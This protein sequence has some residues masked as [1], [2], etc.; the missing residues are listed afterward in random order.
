MHSKGVSKEICEMKEMIWPKINDKHSSRNNYILTFFTLNYASTF[1]IWERIRWPHIITFTSFSPSFRFLPLCTLN[2]FNFAYS[3]SLLWRAGKSLD[4]V[5]VVA[6]NATSI[7]VRFTLPQI[8]VGL[9]GHAELVFTSQP[10]LP[11]HEWNI[12]KFARPKRLFDTPNIEYHLSN[13]KP[14]TTYYFQ[15]RIVVEA[16]Q[17]GPESEIYKLRMPSES[18]EPTTIRATTTTMV[19]SS[20][21][22]VTTEASITSTTRKRATSRLKITTTTKRPI[23]LPPV[24][25]M[26]ENDVSPN[27]S[28]HGNL[29]KAS[30]SLILTLFLHTLLHYWSE[31]LNEMNLR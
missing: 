28:N 19:T 9:V 23:S 6:M 7:R 1:F 2:P 24:I 11:R 8:L 22:D 29:V 21:T 15:L 17:S 30:L 18:L 4:H 10:T 5:S 16:L 27:M 25:L 13:L 20:S 12:Q 31:Q 26:N 14:D 3:F